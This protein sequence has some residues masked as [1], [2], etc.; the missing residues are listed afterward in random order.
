[1]AL[2]VTVSTLLLSEQTTSLSVLV[3]TRRKS[4]VSVT[5]GAS[6]VDEVA[7]LMSAKALL[8]VRLCHW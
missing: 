1:M 5:A 6:Y 7:R 3:A 2:G 8:P 4:V